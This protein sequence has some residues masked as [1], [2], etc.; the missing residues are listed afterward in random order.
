MIG[1]IRAAL[2]RRAIGSALLLGTG[3]TACA[4]QA[5]SV[6]MYRDPGCG[7][8]LGWAD[9]MEHGGR[10]DVAAVDHPDMAAIKAEHGVPIELRSC[11]TA[12]VDGYVIE[13][14]VPAADVERLLDRRPAGVTG[15]AVAGMPVGSPGMEQGGRHQPY[16]VIAFGP[17]GRAL[18][19]SYPETAA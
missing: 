9:H 18:W 17:A 15:L 16:Q 6:T 4:A 2:F 13:G 3:L 12:T 8:C 1:T 14:H 5:A 19:A 7:C 11:H 10:H